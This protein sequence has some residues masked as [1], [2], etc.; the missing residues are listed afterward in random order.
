MGRVGTKADQGDGVVDALG[1]VSAHLLRDET[2]L[3]RL[4]A[5]RP[6]PHHRGIDTRVDRAVLEDPS[7][8]LLLVVLSDGNGFGERI[9]VRAG[10]S[11]GL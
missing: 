11:S 8:K 3:G 9:V 5:L 6:E 7:S 1:R 2:V 4:T 10:N